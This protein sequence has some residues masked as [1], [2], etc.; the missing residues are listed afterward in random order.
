MSDI[1]IVVTSN[2]SSIVVTAPAGAGATI[3]TGV[4]SA[5]PT[6]SASDLT[7]GTLP[8]ARLSAAVP[9]LVSGLIP[10]GL[11][12]SYVDDVVEYANLAGFPA[13]GEAGK[14]FV[15]IATKK[16][17]RWSGSV[18][19]EINAAPVQSVSGRT[20]AVTLTNAD[21]GL[22]SVN[23][24]SD[25]AKPVSAATQTALDAKANLASPTFTGTVSGLTKSM[26]GLGSADNTS[27][28]AKPVS[29][30][31]QT[32]LD[33]LAP[34]LSPAL[35]GVPTAITANADTS[36]TQLATCGFV[37]G[38]AGTNNPQPDGGASAGNSQR[39]ARQ[40]HVHPNDTSRAAIN[41]PTFTGVVTIP[42]G[43]N[44]SGYALTNSP[45]LSGLPNATTASTDENSTRI[46]TC[47]F[48]V[49]QAGS[50]TPVVDGVAAIGSSLRYARQDH[51]H[52][53]NTSL[54][55]INSP[56]F[57]GTPNATTA[58][59]D[60]V[61]TRIATC[62]FVTNQAGSANPVVDGVAAI[63]S[64]LRYAR[65]DHV[66]PTNTNLATL[67]S[68]ALTG[69]PLAPTASA[70]TNTD[71]IAT[72]A[73]VRA[74]VA[75][76]VGT[77]AATL[78][79][80]GELAAALGSDASFSTTI[81]ASIGL[82]AP[83][84]SPTFTG[85]VTIPSGASIS[86]F[87][88]IDSPTFTTAAYA[89]T[90]S[91]DDTTT[92]IATC[93]FV[94]GQAGSNNPTMNSSA[95][96]GTSLR[97]SREDHTHPTD[98]SLAA[99]NSP[100]F[101]GTV[102][103]PTGASIS[104]FAP[105]ASP[106]LTGVPQSTTG[107]IDVSSIQIA[108]Q[109]FVLRQASS[110]S[111]LSNG[112]VAIGSSL[113]YA[114][115]D[116]VHPAGS[117]TASTG[118]PTTI[119]ANQNNYTLPTGADIVRVSSS[120]TYTI[121]GIVAVTGTVIMLANVGSFD[122]RLSHEST[123]STAAN[124]ITTATGLDVVIA[125]NDS[126]TIVY[127]AVSARWRTAGVVKSTTVG[128]ATV[129]DFTRGSATAPAAPVLGQ[130]GQW[131]LEIPATAKHITILCQGA[132]SGG[133]SGRKGALASGRSGGGGGYPGGWC[134]FSYKITDLSS[135]VVKII[136]GAGGAGG[137]SQFNDSTNGNTGSTGGHG[138]VTCGGDTNLLANGSGGASVSTGGTA[139]TAPAG[140]TS[141]PSQYTG[142]V[143]GNIGNSTVAGGAGLYNLHT[144][145]SG[146]GG[147]GAD[148]S[149]VAYAGGVGGAMPVTLGAYGVPAAGTSGGG[150]GAAG[151]TYFTR[152]GTG[153]AGGGGNASA[154][155]NGGAGGNAG[156]GGGGGGGG[157][158]TNS[159]NTTYYSGAGGNGGDAFVRIIV[160]S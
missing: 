44:I 89:P 58:S 96:V 14:I 132:G 100:T 151:A 60:E 131:T 30:A 160:W 67:N 19:V 117:A 76:L 6:T 112:D 118:T 143:T 40:D 153:G 52:P 61:T 17:Y 101:T 62:Q 94:T 69:T 110:A 126:L 129:Y 66:H 158:S 50:A 1:S 77:A 105:L 41:S 55:T 43:A 16:I 8:N 130:T 4:I 124:R 115:Q 156:I 123:S 33:L 120:A 81:A 71:Q 113:R 92:K 86:G 54:A 68:P 128:V 148:A 12:P 121:T 73:F 147:G 154:T 29:A 74:E 75:A 141:W 134:E 125:P 46:A 85:T 27:D 136:V 80:L 142:N 106:T 42:S 137:A 39:Y 107:T 144:S 87:A 98:T 11:L 9:I 49:G 145:G 79:T 114:R 72:T 93:Q 65:Q 122:V 45:N 150:A 15:D 34:L 102:T 157:G 56:S 64:S 57:T 83:I 104:G 36:S 139:T 146:G 149:N 159:G 38:Q 127:D 10:S 88:P 116:H 135:N 26:V 13:T 20:G 119:A 5:P 31:T 22:G 97:Y 47:A 18:Y 103:I 3:N 152:W 84:E 2:T 82:K 91:A 140:I 7:S 109:E 28:N 32:A 155:G 90:A 51:V 95:G 21:V 63:G 108:T 70:A 99:I 37:L 35:T 48:V 53:I 138:Q 24:T 23:N 59:A 78:D 133:G 111:P 25:N